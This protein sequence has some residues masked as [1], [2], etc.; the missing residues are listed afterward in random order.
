MNQVERMKVRESI[1][2]KMTIDCEHNNAQRMPVDL[3]YGP[4][5]TSF[6]V[7]ILKGSTILRL[8]HLYNFLYS[9]LKFFF[10]LSSIVENILFS[11]FVCG[12]LDS[13]HESD[14]FAPRMGFLLHKEWN[15]E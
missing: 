2:S 7:A 11:F 4:P 14:D 8:Q 9:L 15:D 12:Q 13:S 6:L 5:S 3:Q 1:G 10:N